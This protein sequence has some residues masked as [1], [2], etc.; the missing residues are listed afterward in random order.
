MLHYQVRMG[1]ISNYNPMTLIL[2]TAGTTTFALVLGC[3]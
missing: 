1:K 2:V 3:S